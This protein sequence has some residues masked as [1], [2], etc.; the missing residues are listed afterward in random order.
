MMPPMQSLAEA[1][2][3]NSATISSR[4]PETLETKTYLGLATALAMI[5][6]ARCES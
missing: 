1:A 6:I 5:G 2:A 3:L 4:S